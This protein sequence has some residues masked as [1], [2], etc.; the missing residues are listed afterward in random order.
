M[1]TKEQLSKYPYFEELFK[2]TDAGSV[3]DSLTGL[4]ARGYMVEFIRSLI[5]SGIPFALA[6]LDLDNFKFINDTY[7]HR[8]GDGVLAGVSGD[9]AKYLGDS[10][11]AGRFGGDEFLIVNFRD[12]SYDS[13]KDFFTGMYSN[14]TVL[15]KNIMLDICEPF[16]TGTIGSAVF[17]KDAQDYA[18]LFALVDKTLYRGKTKGRNCYIIYVEEKHKDISMQELAGRGMYAIFH[19][20]SSRFDSRTALSG[21]LQAMLDILKEDMRIT[22]LYYVGQDDCFTSISSGEAFGSV[23]DLDKLTRETVY[24]TNEIR[25]IEAFSPSMHGLCCAKE[26]ET[27]L[28]LRVGI[29]NETFGYLICAEAKNR[30]IWQDDE[31]A[32]LFFVARMLAV[33]LHASG[34]R[35]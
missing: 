26:F 25:H 3:V 15:R 7:G 1:Y 5:A 29:Q 35:I 21:K 20:L 10:G 24:T 31:Y 6:L 33:Y 34:E 14:F 4:V 9:L 18:S 32:I 28:I 22:D 12:C 16:I 2:T 17:P 8:I 13:L 27:V 30:R 19:D 11:V 23:Y